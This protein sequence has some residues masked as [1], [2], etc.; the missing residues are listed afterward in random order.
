V[1]WAIAVKILYT[2]TDHLGSALQIE[3]TAQCFAYCLQSRWGSLVTAGRFMVTG[4]YDSGPWLSLPTDKEGKVE[5][6][7]GGIP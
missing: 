1:A 3:Q 2:T 6:A 7:Q 5:T 4:N